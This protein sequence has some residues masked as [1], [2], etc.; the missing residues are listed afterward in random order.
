MAHSTFFSTC[1]ASKNSAPNSRTPIPLKVR[2]CERAWRMQAKNRSKW[3]K[4]NKRRRKSRKKVPSRKQPPRNLL[5]SLQ[6][7]PMLQPRRNLR[8][9]LPLPR[10]RGPPKKVPFRKGKGRRKEPKRADNEEARRPSV[11]S[12]GNQRAF[13]FLGRKLLTEDLFNQPFKSESDH[14][15]RPGEYN[16][17]QMKRVWV[18]RIE[19][20]KPVVD[21]PEF[22]L[23]S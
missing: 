20:D 4:G 3:R 12:T 15:Q 6:T 8:R 23:P 16:R 18:M 7:W 1:I 17:Q 21:P 5:R 22:R 14:K 19:I 13:R 11:H 10:A 9:K 2:R